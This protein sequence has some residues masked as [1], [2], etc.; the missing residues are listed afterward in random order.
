MVIQLEKIKVFIFGTGLGAEKILKYINTDQVSI[1]GYI[2]NKKL[3]EKVEYNNKQIISP[4]DLGLY[5]FDFIIIGSSTYAEEMQNQLLKLGIDNKKIIIPLRRTMQQKQFR[6]FY[7]KKNQEYERYKKALKPEYLPEIFNDFGLYSIN[8]GIRESRKI[9]LME[10]PDYALK[11]N[12]YVRL[13]TLELL[14]R[15][16]EYKQVKGSIAELGVYQ[17]DFTKIIRDLFPQKKFY[18]FD[19]FEGFSEKDIHL[20][21]INNYSIA[22]AGRF[23][24]TNLEIVLKKIKNPD[25]IIVRKGYFPE[26]TIGLEDECFAFVSIDVDLYQPT[27]EGLKYF[28]KRLSKGGYILIHDYNFDKYKGVKSAVRD[29]CENENISYTPISDYFGSVLITK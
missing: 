22:K 6:E 10:Y 15:E 12:D 26:T 11:G 1:E 3:V 5:D 21:E 18:L 23:E 24:D 7:V 25:N 19:T 16:L 4:N 17:G 29:Y 14:S 8:Q 20:E 2:D 13:S 28:Y 9:N 27:L